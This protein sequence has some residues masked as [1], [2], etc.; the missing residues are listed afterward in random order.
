MKTKKVLKA[1]HEAM[2]LP[3]WCVA[4]TN[5]TINTSRE[6]VFL[7]SNHQLLNSPFCKAH[8]R[9]NIFL[10]QR[11]C[12]YPQATKCIIIQCFKLTPDLRR[13][14][15]V[16]S[17]CPCVRHFKGKHGKLYIVGKLNKRRFWKKI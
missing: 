5:H 17:R 1:K 2:A 16:S 6:L 11:H 4:L 10:Q 14:P 13:C 7:S 8:S 9:L 12:F 15:P 3:T